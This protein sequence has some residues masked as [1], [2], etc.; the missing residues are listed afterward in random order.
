MENSLDPLLSGSIDLVII[1][2]LVTYEFNEKL[3]IIELQKIKSIVAVFLSS[4]LMVFHSYYYYGVIYTFIERE[5]YG[6]F[7]SSGNKFYSMR[8]N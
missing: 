3:S 4:M 1:V 2:I 5:C 8:P 6:L 7:Y